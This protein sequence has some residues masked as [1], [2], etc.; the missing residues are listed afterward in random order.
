MEMDEP[1]SEGMGIGPHSVW[2]PRIEEFQWPVRIS[3]TP[4]SVHTKCYQVPTH[5]DASKVYKIFSSGASSRL[6]Q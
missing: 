4:P 1:I 6:D 3:C 2:N 5:L